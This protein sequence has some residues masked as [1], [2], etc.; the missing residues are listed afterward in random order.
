VGAFCLLLVV[1]Q[2]GWCTQR[3]MIEDAGFPSIG[4][5]SNGTG[6]YGMNGCMDTYN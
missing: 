5:Y 2:H 6:N 1:A 3:A 4:V